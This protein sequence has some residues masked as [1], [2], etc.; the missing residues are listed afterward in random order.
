[1]PS[2]EQ[3]AFWAQDG[4]AVLEAL[5]SAPRGLAGTEAARRLDRDGPATLV[6]RT[7]HRGVRLLL[8]QFSGPV[9]LLLL[10]AAVIALVLGDTVDGAVILTIVLASG[11][12]GY[13]QERGADRTMAAL[14]ARVHVTSTVLRDGAETV[15]RPD[16]IVLGD[17]VVLRAGDLVPADCRVLGSRN[18]LVDQAALTGESFP[19]EKTAGPPAAADAPVPER[20]TALYLG[21]HVVSGA[22]EAV[23]VAVGR[24]TEFGQVAADLQSRDVT[25][26]F[27]RGLT[28]FGLLL[29]RAMAVLVSAIFVIDLL[30]GRPLVDSLLFS[31]ALAVGLTPQMMPAIV[32]ISLSAGARRMAAE[33]VV[34]KR[35][36]AIEDL[37]GMT[38]LCTDKTGTLTSGDV[39]LRAA[40]APDGVADDEVLR[41]AR[42]N[43]GLQRGFANPLD[44][45]VLDGVQEV[46]PGRALGEVP[47]DFSRRR[48]SVL[49]G[50]DAD[51]PPLLV[52]KGAFAETVAVCDRVELD[53]RVSALDDAA[54][55]S[56]WDAQDSL[57][58]EGLRVLALATRQLP[59]GVQVSAADERGMTLRGLLAFEDPPRADAVASVARLRE[60]GVG[61]RLVTGDSAAA[62]RV[63]AAAVGLS[64]AGMLT[65]RDLAALDDRALAARLSA[66]EVVA[67]VDPLEKERVVRQLRRRGEVVGFLGDGI[68]DAPALHAADVGLSVDT[69]V[70]V[71]KQA[72]DV[73]LLDKSL[74]VVADGVVLGRSTFANTLKYVRVTVSANFGNMLSMAAAAAFLPFLPMLPR[75]ILV[76]NF[77]SDIPGTTIAGDSVDPEQVARA[78]AWDTRSIRRFMVT[79]GLI[80]T[81]FDLLTFLVL[82]QVFRADAPLFRS[83]WFVES[84]L[85]ELAVMLVLRTGR[86]FYRSRPGVGL[87][88]TSGVVAVVVVAL[89]FTPLAAPLGLV[90]LP[91]ALLATLAV[92]LAL[93][94]LMNELAKRALAPRPRQAP[95]PARSLLRRRRRPPRAPSSTAA[96]G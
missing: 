83:G 46:P 45:A 60:V 86:P 30:L 87:R 59:T 41:L 48:L 35:L 75:Q 40:L 29:V 9:V 14:L 44:R 2:V 1:M 62:A 49:V 76:L 65:G 96:R 37:G 72:A 92:L 77:L 18:L 61:V 23:V 4:T 27:E 34:V 71:A 54:L 66:A 24:A 90:P 32:A 43:A 57:A 33:K 20:T 15:V 64:P 11:L 42:L 31:L 13:W 25:T 85:T 58:A 50:A 28:D 56:V 82:R 79:F 38:V 91:A 3:A 21:S 55:R 93:Y 94:V 26:A 7:R 67:E 16:E 47:Y 84:T 81:A 70:D 80:S 36:D 73:V 51:G 22:G 5:D 6:A 74:G 53:G 63:V 78:P 12:L 39:R 89:P 88:L 17:V 8:S 52:T 68:N 95:P 10:V 69:A 19:V